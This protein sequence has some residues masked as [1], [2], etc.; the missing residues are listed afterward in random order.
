MPRTYD[1]RYP[2][3]LLQEMAAAERAGAVTVEVPSTEF[4][5]LVELGE[6][7]I[8]VVV[9]DR[10]L[11][12]RRHLMGEQISHAVLSRGGPVYAAGEIEVVRDGSEQLVILVN[13]RSGHYR[14]GPES[15]VVARQALEARGLRVLPGSVQARGRS[16]P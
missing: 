15:L 4:E 6:P 9:G 13:N 5:T 12:C 16:L 14:P 8:Y 10:P 2:E 3:H 1:N 11:V 7:M